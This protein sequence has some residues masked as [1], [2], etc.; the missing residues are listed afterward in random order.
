MRENVSYVT[1]RDAE[2]SVCYNEVCLTTDNDFV[3]ARNTIMIM[4]VHL[5]EEMERI[6]A[7]Q[8]NTTKIFKYKSV[9]APSPS[10]RRKQDCYSLFP[11]VHRVN[12]YQRRS[13][14]GL[15]M[16]SSVVQWTVED[17]LQTDDITMV[18]SQRAAASHLVTW[19]AWLLY[20]NTW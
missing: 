1:N 4:Y 15:Q 9:I 17:A 8:T 5:L 2:F 14:R 11:D 6:N 18:T 20:D 16:K 12:S 7:F 13:N 19:E 10:F 3:T